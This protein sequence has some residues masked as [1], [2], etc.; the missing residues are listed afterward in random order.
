[1]VGFLSL[2]AVRA[3]PQFLKA[4]D[5][6]GHERVLNQPGRV[7][8]VIYSNQSV[9]D[10]TRQAGKSLDEF[11]GLAQFRSVVVVD[12]RGSLANWVS[13]YA[14]RR[15]VRDLDKEAERI[16]PAY[17][18][19]G[20]RA[21]PRPE[22][23]AVADFQGD[24]CRKLGWTETVKTLRVVVYNLQGLEDRR[25]EDLKSESELRDTVRA[26]LKNKFGKST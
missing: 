12:L 5:V 11:Q 24:L 18:K 3:E 6:D 19:N 1:V 15:M 13:G 9:Q 21:D 16:R 25:W 20:S 17:V 7:T 26:C 10:L 22:V 23:S 8:V 14:Q 2:S 4:L